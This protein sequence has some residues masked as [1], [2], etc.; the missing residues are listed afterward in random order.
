LCL[1][2]REFCDSCTFKC[3]LAIYK[4]KCRW[5]VYW[6]SYIYNWSQI[7]AKITSTAASLRMSSEP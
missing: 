1:T 7:A 4:H 6:N 2:S 5:C 3:K